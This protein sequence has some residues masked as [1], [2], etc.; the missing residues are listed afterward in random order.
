[1]TE[2]PSDDIL[3]AYKQQQEQ[4]NEE[5]VR[6][7]VASFESG[8]FPT[9]KEIV[10]AL[11]GNSTARE[12]ALEKHPFT[13]ELRV[14]GGLWS[15]I[16]SAEQAYLDFIRTEAVLATYA[17]NPEWNRDIFTHAIDLPVQKEVMAFCAAFYGIKET[18]YR[19][20][21]ARPDIK[22]KIDIAIDNHLKQAAGSR[23]VLCLRTNLSH[24]SV[25]IPG[26]QVTTNSDGSF[27]SVR[28]NIK[29]LI[30][31]GDWTQESIEFI[32]Q[33]E[34]KGSLLLAPI[35]EEVT[36]ALERFRTELKKELSVAVTPKEQ[37]YYDIKD[38]ATR[39]NSVQFLKIITQ[40]FKANNRDPYRFLS[41]FFD[42]SQVR[43]IMR[44]PRNS[45]E[46]VDYM[47]TLASHKFEID[48]E[49]RA[50][51][52]DLFDVPDPSD[53]AR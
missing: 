15:L 22:T 47:L 18:L 3:K 30:D 32:R 40:K 24:G 35:L 19:L 38:A 20:K 53:D 8:S 23:F 9:Q 48:E 44:L 28:F 14:R 5:L 45:R 25:S 2:L 43:H 51:A 52:Y 27:G 13:H 36:K 31:H 46:Q 1:M 49:A 16:S 33:R 37:D 11:I 34:E 21:S 10:D 42:D 26:W 41:M 39:R 6:A 50:K 12:L 7:A 4:Q 29:A 17:N